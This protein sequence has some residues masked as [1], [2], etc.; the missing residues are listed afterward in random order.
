MKIKRLRLAG[1]GPF[2]NEQVVDFER[3]DDDGIFLITGKTGAGKSSILDAVCFALYGSVPRYEGTESQLRSDHCEPGDPTFVELEFGLNGNDYRIF[4]TPRYL[5]AKKRGIGTTV[6]APDARLEIRDAAAVDAAADAVDGWRGLAARPVDVGNELSRILPLKQDQFLQVILLAQNRFQRFLL[7]KTDDRR[8]VLR[9]LFGTSRFQ[10]L[11]TELITRRKALDDELTG[12]R[13]RLETLAA[14]AARHVP[15]GTEPGTAAPD[16]AWFEAAT[17]E[18]EQA[19]AVAVAAAARADAALVDATA[20]LRAQEEM[21]A[22][23]DRRDAATAT[24]AVLDERS[25]VVDADRDDL[26]AAHRAARVWPQIEAE[27]AALAAALDAARAE[28]AA[29]ENWITVNGSDEVDQDGDDDQDAVPLSATID[30]L[31]EQLGSL[32]DVLAAEEE[33]PA[34]DV[35]SGS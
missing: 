35:E 32:N 26:A 22:R 12:V 23:Q 1:F 20:G 18:L 13:V 27:S 21:R 4:R 25:S 30:L 6:S 16:L 3:F 5:K 19:L 2:K 17:A 29:R 31:L 14:S 34:L 24:L 8:E 10:S 15:A 7:A 28:V 33:L 11:E 9:T